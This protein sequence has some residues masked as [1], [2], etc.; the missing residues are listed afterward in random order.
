MLRV[1]R[2]DADMVAIFNQCAGKGKSQTITLVDVF[3]QEE[4]AT[5]LISNGHTFWKFRC[6]SETKEHRF[7]MTVTGYT[8]LHFEDLQVFVFALVIDAIK[9]FVQNRLND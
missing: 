3:F 7:F 2:T 6:R 5:S 4:H 1:N 8:S 9:F